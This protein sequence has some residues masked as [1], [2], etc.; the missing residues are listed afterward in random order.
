MW[1]LLFPSQEGFMHPIV[2]KFGQ[3]VD[4]LLPNHPNGARRLL[5][6]GFRLNGFA[7]RHFVKKTSPARRAFADVSNRTILRPFSA[8]QKSA[9]VSL[10]TPCELLQAFDLSPMFPEGLSCYLS[11]AGAERG[12]IEAAENAGVPETFCSYHKIILGAAYTGVLPRPRFIY[13]TSLACDANTLTFRRLAEFYDVPHFVLDVP[14]ACTPETIEELAG[15]LQEIAQKISAL[16]GQPLPIEALRAAVQRSEET[17]R[18]YR[19][20]LALRA[21][22]SMPDEMTSE[23][24]AIFALHPLL[25]SVSS[26]EFAKALKE[27]ARQAPPRG[28]ETRLLWVHTMPN[29][30]NAMIQLLDFSKTC[31]IVSCDLCFDEPVLPVE[32]DADLWHLMAR[33]LIENHVNGPAQ[34]RI[35]AVLRQAQALDADGVVWFCHWGC[36][37]TCGAGALAK[38]QLEQ[39]G[40]PTLLLDGDG[41]DRANCAPGQMTTRMQAF[42]E[43]LEGKHS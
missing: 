21:Q 6:T 24:Y 23:M 33:R 9:M 13:N 28:Q 17:L 27:E 42:L 22:K 36:R 26:L 1:R 10:F 11:G 5:T 43:L 16:L 19:E 7:G 37:E 38:A 2:E 14:F 25:G 3:V 39:A 18:T 31:Q 4:G 20:Y 8:P 40:F 34:R 41:C 35:D 12:F 32:K 29:L 30:D 15:Q